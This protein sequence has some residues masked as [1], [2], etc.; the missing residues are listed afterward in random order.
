MVFN[1][2]K[3]RLL[4]SFLV[5][6]LVYGTGKSY[7]QNTY[8]VDDLGSDSN[9]G[10]AEL[11]FRTLQKASDTVSAGDTVYVYDGL[12][13]NNDL[14]GSVLQIN[15][16]GNASQW[17]TFKN[18]PGHNPVISVPG[19]NGI[20]I[21]PGANYIHVEGFEVVGDSRAINPSNGI[22]AG[23]TNQ[24]SLHNIVIRGN[25]VRDLGGGGISGI[26]T[27]YMTIE[28]NIVTNTSWGEIASGPNAGKSFGNSGI[29]IWLP[30][31]I[32]DGAG[33]HN[34]IRR[35]VSA[36]NF[37]TAPFFNLEQPLITDGN[38]IIIDNF[39]EFTEGGYTARTLVENN[40]V[41]NNGGRGIHILKSDFVDV[42]HNT[43]VGNNLTDDIANDGGLNV[44]DGDDIN[45]INNISISA[46][47]ET[48]QNTGPLS[49]QVTGD[50]SDISL[51]GNMLVGQTFLNVPIGNN[52][53][54]TLLNQLSVGLNFVNPSIDPESADFRLLANSL[55]IDLGSVQNFTSEDADGNIRPIG[56]G[57]DVGAYEY[58]PSPSTVS[59]FSVLIFLLFNRRMVTFK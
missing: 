41:Y 44:V 28:D 45:L 35:N 56:S 24:G 43:I 1:S 8:H 19:W 14:N 13:T 40:V 22:I 5:V 58:I 33:Y 47:E 26:H 53:G 49:V 48:S 16:S 11:P 20:S 54:N 3:T 52:Q 30:Q 50:S 7:A 36:G 2:K 18:A 6:L 31:Q 37:N 25:R 38:G 32:D 55:A 59:L 12:Y 23:R 15:T 9:P 39:R 27:D 34:I 46:F 4:Y 57:Y 29:S 21:E 51:V 17:I 10:T 42:V